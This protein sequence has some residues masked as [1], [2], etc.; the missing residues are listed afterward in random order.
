MWRISGC[1]AV[2]ALLSFPVVGV[3]LSSAA[4]P[5]GP[6][7][8]DCELKSRGHS[9]TQLWLEVHGA[10]NR[11]VLRPGRS[12]LLP[13]GRYR[14]LQVLLDGGRYAH[15]R[16]S[17]E[18][19]WFELAPGRP[20]ELVVGAPLSRR[21]T[22]TRQG[23]FLELGWDL[24]DAAGRTYSVKTGLDCPAPPK[25]AVFQGDRKIGSGSFRYG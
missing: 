14:V 25:F 17:P 6:S 22:A 7:S 10:A 20:H 13:A 3:S 4:E 18:E 1:Q 2:V 16:Q 8:P 11:Q 9:V 12:V 15:V 23:R 24:V 21:L 19:E 5:P